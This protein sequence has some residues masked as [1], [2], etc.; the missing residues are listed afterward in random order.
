MREDLESVVGRRITDDEMIDFHERAAIMQYDGGLS[1]ESA[2]KL[3][4]DIVF[5]G[6]Q[7][8]LFVGQKIID[9]D[10][11]RTRYLL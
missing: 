9:F 1:R 4:I 11:D 5:R 2:E 6:E 10:S 7:V 3:A 8:G